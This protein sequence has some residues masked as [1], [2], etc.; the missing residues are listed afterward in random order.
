MTDE[1]DYQIES[2]VSPLSSIEKPE[3]ISSEYMK[4][5]LEEVYKSIERTIHKD[6]WLDYYFD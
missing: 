6:R 4:K 5:Y 1:E 2:W 3:K